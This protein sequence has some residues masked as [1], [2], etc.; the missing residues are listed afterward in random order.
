MSKTAHDQYID[1]DEEEETCPLCIEDFD[2]TDKGFKPCPCGYQIC[3][4]CYNSIKNNMNGLCPACRRPYDDK[5]I[6]YKLIT[7]EETAAYKARQAQKQKKT[8]AALQKEKQK[9]EADSLSRK[10]LAG[11]RVVQK[12]LVYVTG[13]AP[14]MQ[15]DELLQTLRGEKYFGRYGK[16]IKIV[17]SKAR[18]KHDSVGVYVT[19]ERKDDA[20]SCIA[21]VDGFVSDDRTLR[22]QFGTTKYCSAYLRGDTCMN[23]NCMFLHEPGEAKDSYSRAD[24][25]ALNAGSSQQGDSK[26]PPP[27]SQQPVSAAQPMTRQPSDQPSSP[28]SDRPALPSTASWASKPAQPTRTESRPAHASEASP[29][30]QTAIPVQ[31]PVRSAKATTEPVAQPPRPQKPRVNALHEFVKNF[32]PTGLCFVWNP[33]SVTEAERELIENYPALFDPNGG[34]RRR[35][36]K[37]HEE[38]AR[39]VEI[40]EQA[41]RAASDG[42]HAEITPEMSGSMQ[43]GGEPEERQD[44]GSLQ[45]GG[46]GQL[47]QRFAFGDVTS[48]S[49]LTDRGMTP[50]Q[51]QQFLLQNL[52]SG[53]AQAGF[54]SAN[55]GG[56]SQPP[57]HQRNVSRFSFANDTASAS[58]AVKPVANPKLLNQQS[59]MM[60]PTG[61]F[62]QQGSNFFTSNVQ[63]PPPGLKTTGTPPVSGGMTFGQGH[64]F[65][66]GGL[67]Y[68]TSSAS[69]T[70]NQNEEMMRD[71]M[72]NRGADGAAKLTDEEFPPLGPLRQPSISSIAPGLQSRRS[73]PAL[74]PGLEF[75]SRRGTPTVPPG[76]AHAI[77]NDKDMTVLS[78]PSGLPILEPIGSRPSSRASLRRVASTQIVPALPLRVATPT[79]IGSQPGT[80]ARLVS[81]PVSPKPTVEA[82][83]T[84][85]KKG[86][87]RAVGDQIGEN[88]VRDVL[89]AAGEKLKGRTT[90]IT[91]PQSPVNTKAK[92]EEP[93]AHKAS[94]AAVA[95]S[96]PVDARDTKRKHPGKLD[97]TAAVKQ[98][99]EATAASTSSTTDTEVQSMAK[100]IASQ[101]AAA[102]SV[103]DSPVAA[104]SPSSKPAPRT[105]RL[106][107]TPKA[108][109]PPPVP[110]AVLPKPISRKL[111]SR[112]PS[113][114]SMNVPGTPTSEHISISD[115]ISVTSTTQ[116]RANSPPPLISK[117]G[118]APVRTKTKS[119]LKK[120]RQERAK[121][122]EES[123]V[124][125]AATVGAEEPAQEAI[126]GR[127][128]D[129]Q[130]KEVKPKP[131]LVE[132]VVESTP[133][134]SRPASPEPVKAEPSPPP[135]PPPPPRVVEPLSPPATPTLS[136]AQL[137]TEL[138]T[139][140]E[141]AKSFEALFRVPAVSST[142]NASSIPAKDID[143]H[144]NW[145]T[146]EFGIKLGK[147]DVDKLL[148]GY[149]AA[150][151]WGGPEDSIWSRALIT[152]GGA[153]LRALTEDLEQRFLELERHILSLPEE[154]RFRPTKPQNDTRFPVMDLKALKKALDSKGPRGANVMEQM[155]Q[156]GSAMKKG[157][158]LVDEVTKYI[159]EFVMP[160]AT[161]PPSAGRGA[162]QQTQPELAQPHGAVPRDVPVPSIDIAERQL[163][164]AKRAVDER[165]GAL[166]RAIKKN[167]KLLGLN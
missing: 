117:V 30:Q 116:S 9:A 143:S 43:L 151:G 104:P 148:S 2:L 50:Q 162:A 153:Q 46:D 142:K 138:R 24:L 59:A 149:A 74:P 52:R 80:P 18:D 145:R 82:H 26:P 85:T 44:L 3:Q 124:E 126:I 77:D 167:K 164:D 32:D 129:S 111:P 51:H 133:V 8:Q 110:V 115:N 13:I 38:D 114:A 1:A 17:V 76:L 98:Q 94:A 130:G 96:P 86:K 15:E 16:I 109:T 22:A 41:L 49:G 23:R 101:T 71:L 20:A 119:Q 11:L 118:S 155:V 27:Q 48:S 132:A 19:Y 53:S 21:A 12:N 7:P 146:T 152:P 5:Q 108:E 125:S 99:P 90:D 55:A 58:A 159:N 106:V 14:K 68:G 36:R 93:A 57:G 156:D 31:E 42:D 39:R 127:K 54:S 161:P 135:P 100:R 29:A 34:S 64:G 105:I 95:A 63:G 69:S 79:K 160:P 158:F 137:L 141:F 103:S 84:P 121:A 107:Q 144:A 25:S 35:L 134:V 89:T 97:I 6:E 56:A 40:E 62:Q 70:R 163:H 61:S 136:T 165:E 140:S 67:P 81:R 33:Q 75:S 37:E 65:T 45:S 72:R 87:G 88:L 123:K 166:R 112:Q 131:K 113:I 154:L 28:S 92:P 120:E 83:E 4:F 150:L 102:S 10:H 47:D 66:T 157:A 91:T 139:N 122:I 147:D 60:P 73:T 78:K 128:E